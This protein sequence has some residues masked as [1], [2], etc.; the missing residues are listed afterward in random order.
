MEEKYGVSSRLA[1]YACMVDLLCRQGNVEEALCFVN[2]MLMEPDRR[3]WGAFLAGCRSR[4]DVSTEMVE[5]VLKWL[6][7]LDPENTSFM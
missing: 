2:K 3:I 5:S 6:S 4:P 7:A 1:H